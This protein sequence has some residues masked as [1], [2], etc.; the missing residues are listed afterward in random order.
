ME[1]HP[2]VMFGGHGSNSCRDIKYL[3]C[4]VNSRNLLIERSS[5]F[6]SRRFSRYVNL[7]PSMVA[8]GTVEVEI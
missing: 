2:L 6:M 8:V 7:S 5:N 4:Q 1:S 3:I